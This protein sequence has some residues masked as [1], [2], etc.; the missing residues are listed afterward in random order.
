MA[1][2]KIYIHEFIDII[3]HNRAKYM[4][5]MTANWS[6]IGQ[7]ERHQLCYGVWG[8]VGSTKSWPEVLNIWEEDGWDG[9]ANS[10]RLE[11]DHASLQNPSLAE[12]WSVAAQFRRGGYDRLLIPAPWTRTIEQLCA[13]GVRGECYA[14]E[15]VKC[16]PGTSPDYL[17]LVRDVAMPVYEK[18]GWQLAG[19]FETAMVNDSE[20]ITLWAIPSWEAWA[21]F[22]K[23]QHRD[24]AIRGWRNQ[25]R[26]MAVD[27]HRFLLVDAPLCPFRTGR[28][29]R[30]SDRQPLAEIP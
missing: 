20:C 15:L 1:N 12:W 10:F 25:A 22:E 14:H 24:E 2:D 23:A 7:E 19:A 29:P 27:W 28:Q 18:Y 26:G 16:A 11:F 9:M 8:V 30:V 6:P 3:G 13:D 21:E 17:K 5:H 4:H